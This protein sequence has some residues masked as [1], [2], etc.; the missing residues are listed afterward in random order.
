[1]NYGVIGQLRICTDLFRT[2]LMGRIAA[3]LGAI[4]LT[5]KLRERGALLFPMPDLMIADAVAWC[6]WRR[7]DS[8]MLNPFDFTEILAPVG[9]TRFNAF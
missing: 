1:M 2:L 3:G 5:A 9:K 4:P 7:L 8:V 6:T